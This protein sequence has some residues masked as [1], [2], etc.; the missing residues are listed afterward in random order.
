L[1]KAAG[2][3]ELISAPAVQIFW[4]PSRSANECFLEELILLGNITSQKPI[5]GQFLQEIL[6][7]IH[8]PEALLPLFS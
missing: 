3:E 2:A 6:S 5:A 7:I 1:A 4:K 8:R